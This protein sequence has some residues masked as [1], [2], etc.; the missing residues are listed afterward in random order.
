[1]DYE[2]DEN[3]KAN[4]KVIGVG[5][6]G[7]NAVNRMIAEDVKGVEFI[8]AN[9]DVQALKNSIQNSVCSVTKSV[10]RKRSPLSKPLIHPE[11]SWQ[12]SE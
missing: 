2:V 6:A 10:E 1:M 9:T 3:N 4:I 11:D 12:V 7:G 5:G 8:A